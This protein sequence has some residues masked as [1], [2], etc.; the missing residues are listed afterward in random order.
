LNVFNTKELFNTATQ[1]DAS[2]SRRLSISD[3]DFNRLKKTSVDY[4]LCDANDKPLLCIEFDGL[5]DGFNVGT[6]YAHDREPDR[7]REW[8]TELKLKVAHGSMFPLFVVGWDHFKDLSDTIKLTIVDGI[9][10]EVLSN[11]ETRDRFSQGFKP[12]EAGWKPDDFDALSPNEQYAVFEDWAIGVEV[13]SELKHN[14][15]SSMTCQLQWR[16]MHLGYSVEY[17]SSPTADDDAT[18]V[19][20]RC[21][22]TDRSFKIGPISATVWLPN[23]KTPGFNSGLGLVENLAKLLAFEKANKVMGTSD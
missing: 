22:V 10:G 16:H 4:T 5:K 13:E 19:G 9:I 1:S 3:I 17:L 2:R 11:R 23:F 18:S 20:C 7:W 8:I 21:I 12:E 14:P 15:I 6:R